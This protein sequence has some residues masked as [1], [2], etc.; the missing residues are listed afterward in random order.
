MSKGFGSTFSITQWVCQHLSKQTDYDSCFV[1]SLA[2][3]S[4]CA[5][6]IPLTVLL[7][8]FAYTCTSITYYILCNIQAPGTLSWVSFPLVA[9]P[10]ERDQHSDLCV[11][12]GGDSWHIPHFPQKLMQVKYH[13]CWLRWSW[14]LMVTACMSSYICLQYISIR[15]CIKFGALN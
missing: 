1:S 4:H 3:L 2:Q 9:S 5:Y 14:T 7:R 12:P 13:Y 8:V 10:T 11:A 15:E 6:A